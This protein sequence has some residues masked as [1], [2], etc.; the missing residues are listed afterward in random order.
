MVLL[1]ALSL[2]EF[3]ILLHFLEKRFRKFIN[4]DEIKSNNG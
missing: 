1:V 2:A 4:Y 3:K